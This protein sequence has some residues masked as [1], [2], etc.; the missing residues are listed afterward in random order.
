[1]F[2]LDEPEDKASHLRCTKS[3]DMAL[4]MDC[5]TRKLRNI[6][7]TSD[8]GKWIDERLVWD[9]W[10]ESLEEYNINLFTLTS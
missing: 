5:F 10:E 9:A 4:A 6:V 1:M 8:D 2:D 3:L 7:D